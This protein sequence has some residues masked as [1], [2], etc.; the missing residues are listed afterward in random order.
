MHIL[1][2]PSWYPDHSNDIKGVFFRDQAQAL[3]NYGHTVGVVAPQM[4]SLRALFPKKKKSKVP[5]FEMDEGVPTY[6]S[7]I[8]AAL[9]RIP[10]GN[11][12]LY[13]RAARILLANYVQE[14]GWPD[15]IHAHST[16]F[17]G[18]VASEWGNENRIPVVITEHSSGFAR[19]LFR[20]WKLKVADKATQGAQSCI[21]VSP[22]LRDVL[23]QQL[24]SSKGRWE[25]IPNVVADRFNDPIPKGSSSEPIRFLNI[26]SMTENKGQN[27]LLKAFK[28]L[29]INGKTAELWIAGDGPIQA[30]IREMADRL[31]I[32]SQVHFLGQVAPDQVPSLLQ[33]VHV[34]VVSSHYETFGVVA[35]E[36]LMAGTPVVAT[37]CGGPECI[38]TERDG[39]LVPTH[40]PQPMAEAMSYIAINYS[41]YDPYAIAE[42]ARSR[43]SGTAV[44]GQ[45][46]HHYEHLLVSS[47]NVPEA[48]T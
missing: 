42:R 15:L 22:S 12:L 21:A 28:K 20:P 45:L 14:I 39:L 37:R 17:A 23:H 1:I 26:A 46:T 29:N 3:A 48:N 6:R 11:Y 19:N 38:V 4:R 9:P 2:L 7:Q 24:P 25:W 34:V 43:F 40:A 33:Q 27:D 36:A 32:S 30:K 31:S 44:A 10:Y 8:L 5:H 16:L 47:S 18:A 41:E 35:A 13:K